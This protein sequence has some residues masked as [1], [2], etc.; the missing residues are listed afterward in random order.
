M[1]FLFLWVL[2]SKNGHDGPGPQAQVLHGFQLTSYYLIAI[3]W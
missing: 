3:A 1:Q 2:G